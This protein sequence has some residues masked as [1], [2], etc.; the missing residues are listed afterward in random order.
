MSETSIRDI[1][2]T[3]IQCY[4]LKN[5]S[6]AGWIKRGIRTDKNTLQPTGE[7]VAEHVALMHTLAAFF[8]PIYNERATRDGFDSLD[9]GKLHT[10]IA[11]HDLPESAPEV[12]DTPSDGSEDKVDKFRKER[13]AMVQISE[14]SNN[15]SLLALWD[16]FEAKRSPEARFATD[17]DKLEMLVQA[18]LYRKQHPESSSQ[19]G[20]FFR[21]SVK[22]QTP[23]GKEILGQLLQ[24]YDAIGGELPRANLAL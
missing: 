12:G 16:E 3:V 8:A 2:E 22:I 13:A 4:S 19:L 1:L 18:Y 7:S 6:R 15:P 14:K 20:S 10:M 9:I 23:L 5:T 21:D 24:L 11:V 17:I